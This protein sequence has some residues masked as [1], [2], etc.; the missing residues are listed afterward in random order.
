ML[1][2]SNSKSGE[3][4]TRD[5]RQ[6]TREKK[7]E[8]EKKQVSTIITYFC[9]GSLA[10]TFLWLNYSMNLRFMECQTIWFVANTCPSYL[11]WH[12]KVS[13]VTQLIVLLIADDIWLSSS[14]S[15]DPNSAARAVKHL[16]LECIA[17]VKYTLFL[18]DSHLLH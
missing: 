10:E 4:K 15:A 18:H 9:W 7:Q 5:G 17:L 3:E 12:K 6:E 8:Y 13:L 14:D 1:Q 11:L 16:P 2:P